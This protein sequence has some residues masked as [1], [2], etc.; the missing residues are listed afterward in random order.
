MVWQ[1]NYKK[2][3]KPALAPITLEAKGVYGSVFWLRLPSEQHKLSIQDY[4]IRHQRERLIQSHLEVYSRMQSIT[5]GGSD[6][7]SVTST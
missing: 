6:Q 1:E 7:N 2:Q 3:H 5:S 4:Y